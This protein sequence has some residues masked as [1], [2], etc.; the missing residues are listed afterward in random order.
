MVKTLFFKPK[1]KRLAKII[2]ITSP[3]AFRKAIKILK[4]GGLTLTE[5]RALILAQNRAKAIL[6]RKTLSTKE[7]KQFEA[8]AKIKIQK[9]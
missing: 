8:I 4:K 6:K 1:S 9:R 2:S 5:R 7:R 3:T